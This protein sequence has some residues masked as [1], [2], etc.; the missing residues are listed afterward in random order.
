MATFDPAEAQKIVQDYNQHLADG[1]PISA[2][3]AQQM[4]DASVGIKNYTENLKNSLNTLKDQTLKLGG[5]LVDGESGLSAYNDVTI[6]GGKAMGDWLVKVPIVGGALKKLSNASAEAV[7]LVNKQADALFQNYQSIS[8][9]GLVTGMQDTFKNLESAGYTV[10]EIK[11]YGELL[12]QNATTL[13]NFGGTA[14][15]GAQQFADVS[16]AIKDSDLETQFMQMGMTVDDINS[17]VVNYIKIQ[18]MS[19]SSRKQT[20]EELKESAK[21]FIEQQDRLAKLTGMNA[22]AQNKLYEHE[23]ARQQFAAH[24]AELEA[25]VAKGGAAGE[26]AKAQIA[27]E[28]ELIMLAGSKGSQQIADDMSMYLAGSVNEPGYNR[29]LKALPKTAKDI[30]GG[31]KGAGEIFNTMT[32]EAVD[33]SNRYAE[34]GKVSAAGGQV[35]DLPGYIKLASASTTDWSKAEKKADDDRKKQAAGLI[36]KSTNNMVAITKDQRNTTQ[37]LD[38]VINKGI[39]PVSKGFAELTKAAQQLVGTAGQAAGKEGQVGGGTT[40]Y[41]KVRGVFGGAPTSGSGSASATV[42]PTTGGAGGGALPGTAPTVGGKGGVAPTTEVPVAPTA[43][44]VPTAP[45]TPTAPAGPVSAAPA[46]SGAL[47]SGMD[48]IKQMII[49]HEGLRTKPY[50][51]SLG[52]WTVGVG[53]LI[54]DGKSLPAGMNREFSKEEVM[55]MFEQDFAKHFSIAQMTPGWDKASETARGAMI[56]L[57]FNMGAWWKKF[58]NTAKALAAGDW[59]GAAAG[60]R[61]SKWAH[62]VKGRAAEITG[63]IEQGGAGGKQ[64]SAAMGGILSGPTSGYNATLHGNEAVVPLPDGKTIPVQTSGGDNS[65]EEISIIARKI[66]T[67]D[68]LISS[69]QKHHDLSRKILQRQS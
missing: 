60:L 29:I 5:K 49:K 55:A 54:G 63:M 59:A 31:V 17:G 30:S 7:V 33:T 14:A 65:G 43:P 39:E 4:R 13:A 32:K 20:T 2:E 37:S 12:K 9:S 62:Q 25:V 27:K 56:D 23:L 52:L 44:G 15:Q 36:S 48:S 28:K 22:A 26:K 24:T 3:L 10:A 64:R 57:A 18:Q 46:T 6:A 19:G 1:K 38:H 69:M 16:A 67:L 34:L 47:V 42:T 61:D 40:L 53:H 58:P 50:Q 35:G 66:S 21:D 11:Q 51:D 45:G 8:R 41:D 68:L